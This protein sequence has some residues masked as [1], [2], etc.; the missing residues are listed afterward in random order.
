[1]AATD[2][3][4]TSALFGYQGRQLKKLSQFETRELDTMT[5]QYALDNSQVYEGLYDVNAVKESAQRP[6]YL[7]TFNRITTA[8][9]SGMT[10]FPT[11]GQGTT[12]QI[13]LS[14]VSFTQNF[15]TWNV[16]GLDNVES[17]DAIMQNAMS[18][19]MRQIRTG[20][21]ASPRRC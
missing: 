2:N 4:A 3:F 20:L 19:A 7:Y 6:L 12:A 15:S 18:Q 13:A 11:G 10:A 21:R 17:F 5:L 14:F 8:N 9:G 16:N 1:M